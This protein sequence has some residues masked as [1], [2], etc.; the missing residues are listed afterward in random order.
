[1]SIKIETPPGLKGTTEQQLSQVYAFLFRLSESLNVALNTLTPENYSSASQV[2]ASSVASSG[3]GS[4][5][6][7]DPKLTESYNE[8]RA[9]INNTATLVRSEMDEFKEEYSGKYIAVSDWGTYEEGILRQ[10]STTA[11]GVVESYDYSSI[12]S[13]LNAQAA[14]FSQYKIDMEGYIRRGVFLDKEG[15]PDV[16]IAIGKNLVVD[17]VID[18]DGVEHEKINNNQSCAFYTAEKVSFLINGNEEAYIS[19]Q[20]LF[21]HNIK[22]TGVVNFNEKW[23]LTTNGP[24]KIKWIGG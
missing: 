17:G 5:I 20:E 19:N 2:A 11:E 24:F 23:M 13:P 1:M 8:L 6:L 7:D 3:Q 14:G 10:V 22:I 9:L 18:V 4:A 21:I 16:G 12:L 15:K